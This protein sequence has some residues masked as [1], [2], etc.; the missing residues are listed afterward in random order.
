[1]RIK[2]ILRQI[3]PPVLWKG[4]R[5]VWHKVRPPKGPLMKGH[6]TN[7]PMNGQDLDVYWDSKMA[8]LL[9]TWGEGN[10][11]VEIKFIMA[12]CKGKVL[13]IACGTGKTIEMLNSFSNLELYGCDISDFLIQKAIDR[14]ILKERLKVCDATKTGYED[15]AFDYSYSI[16][17]LEHFTERGIAQFITETYRITR[18]GSYHMMPV[19]RSGKDE[20][21][22]K[23]YQSFH[24]N[25]VEW[26][27]KQFKRLYKN[28]Y[29]IDSRW[30]DDISVG[31]WFVCFKD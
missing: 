25:S 13:D 6:S 9:E 12:N 29:A 2:E 22:M 8:A 24:N 11:W 7:A 3:I 1:M 19:S 26:W 28:V 15:D 14:G 20:G 4:L 5:F 21:W 31:K 18:H 16:G 10:V 27:E 17:S 30:E 23:T